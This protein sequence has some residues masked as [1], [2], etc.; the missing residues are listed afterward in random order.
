M[1]KSE[2]ETTKLVQE[3][4]DRLFAKG[5][6]VGINFFEFAIDPKSFSNT[7]ENIFYISFLVKE[8]RIS[9]EEVGGEPILSECFGEMG[10]VH[11]F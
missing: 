8:A 2:N 7:V 11:R 5:G 9:I 1:V 3:I 4:H 10:G 6:D